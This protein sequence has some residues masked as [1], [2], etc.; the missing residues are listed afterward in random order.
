MSLRRNL[1]T[2]LIAAVVLLMGGLAVGTVA[3]ASQPDSY[4]AIHKKWAGFNKEDMWL[5]TNG[6]V[7]PVK[8]EIEYYLLDSYGNRIS[9]KKNETLE[10]TNFYSMSDDI[11]EWKNSW[12][13]NQNIYD[14]DITSI[15]EVTK[16]IEFI[17]NY[18]LD[19]WEVT[20]TNDYIM[21]ANVV[22]VKE[23]ESGLIT[24]EKDPADFKDDNQKYEY[25]LIA[26]LKGGSAPIEGRELTVTLT[27]EHPKQVINVDNYFHYLTSSNCAGEYTVKAVGGGDVTLTASD[28]VSG[29]SAGK[30]GIKLIKGSKI[31]IGE[32]ENSAGKSYQYAILDENEE[33][34]EDCWE[35]VESFPVEREIDSD[36][37]YRIVLREIN[38]GGE[39]Q[40]INEID[41]ESEDENLSSDE[42]NTDEEGASSEENTGAEDSDD[43][44]E[45]EEDKTTNDNEN[46][47]DSDGNTGGSTDVIA[48]ETV[49][50]TSG[51]L[52]DDEQNNTGGATDGADDATDK[53]PVDENTAGTPEDNGNTGSEGTETS[54]TTDG[55]AET[56]NMPEVPT[57]NNETGSTDGAA[58]EVF[59]AEN[60]I[61]PATLLDDDED[62]STEP[63]KTTAF[64]VDYSY[65][66]TG[67]SI[68]NIS[69]TTDSMKIF[70]TIV[71]D[72]EGNDAGVVY[73]LTGGD[74]EPKEVT[75]HQGKQ[76][77]LANVMTTGDIKYSLMF[78]G[79]CQVT[80]GN[81]VI[82]ITNTYVPVG[83]Y[84]VVHEYYADEAMTKL[85]GRSVITIQ[86]D[87]LGEKVKYDPEGGEG[88]ANIEEVT[89]P[90]VY[91]DE[92]SKELE[93]TYE[94]TFVAD[95]YGFEPK[96][97][98][99][100]PDADNDDNSDGA[101]VR[102]VDGTP[103]T[104]EWKP[105]STYVEKSKDAED[106]KYVTINKAGNEIVIL[107]YVRTT[108]DPDDPDDP[109]D[110]PKD[111]PEEPDLPDPNDPESPPTVTI[112]DDDVPRTYVRV[113]DPQK[114]EWVYL[115]ED[116]VPLAGRTSAKTADGMAPVFWMFMTGLSVAGVAAFRYSKKK[117]EE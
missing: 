9:D 12:R 35:D 50:L 3:T 64:S 80:Y 116:E 6:S 27:K 18:M 28:T 66:M 44:A 15:K 108:D 72:G 59:D 102:S 19:K 88:S 21:P 89:K 45:N 48:D 87:K 67:E 92:N 43:P 17:G 55:D 69:K 77:D 46:K 97:E 23:N 22:K 76:T 94:Y 32:P 20:Y 10:I 93:N 57:E 90:I 95:A 29:E 103:K 14:L 68:K 82:E 63:V 52:Q 71:G 78:E 24:L 56:G 60:V 110:P 13:D 11:V 74:G 34:D 4:L 105:I 2:Y 31:T 5:L 104:I 100:N 86:Q 58:E 117:K 75:I 96:S 41:D 42:G 54:G 111:P 40:I 91:Y 113:W 1:K 107:K 114:E 73:K 36:G 26:P 62:A 115:P 38:A 99:S 37:T 61:M 33:E 112:T 49:P 106:S 53:T 7:G 47:V 39:P 51:Q 79:S 101:E 98:D 85:D 109:K 83:A 65:T 16:G 84:N 70:A 8:I 25:T 81:L 30:D